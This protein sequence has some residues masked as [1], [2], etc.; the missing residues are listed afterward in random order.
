MVKRIEILIEQL[1]TRSAR[2]SWTL[3][4]FSCLLSTAMILAMQ[5]LVVELKDP[6]KADVERSDK[7]SNMDRPG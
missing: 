3:L 7:P 1:V 2:P 4:A 5:C 6:I